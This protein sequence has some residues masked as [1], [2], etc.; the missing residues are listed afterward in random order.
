MTVKF[1]ES[2][3]TGSHAY[4]TP[5]TESDVDLVVLMSKEDADKL[6][7]LCDKNQSHP[8]DENYITAGGM[9]LRFG[10]LNLI[11]CTNR[12]YFEIWRAGTKRLKKRA[13][14]SREE[15]CRLFRKLKKDEGLHVADERPHKDFRFDDGDGIPF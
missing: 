3:L 2:F 15:A 11:V 12:L 10:K 14:A 13:P 9:S 4:G 8:E 6:Q 1:V 7:S 5:T